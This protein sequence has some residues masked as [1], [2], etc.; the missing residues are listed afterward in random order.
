MTALLSVSKN[1]T[2]KVALYSAD[3]RRMGI[4]VEPPDV[5][6]SDW[7]FT[8]EDRKG[9]T[10]VIRFGLGAVKNVG[11]GPV[12]AILCAR[13]EGEFEDL[14]EFA[15]QVDL[16]KVGRRALESLIKVGALDKFGSRPT[17]L[18]AIERI[19]AI[20]STHFRAAESGQLS[21]FG[22]HTGVEDRIELPEVSFEISQREI[23][24]WERELIGLYVSD[25]P[26]NPVMEALQD[27]VTH[28]SG[29]LAEVS[30]EERVRVAGI[31]TRLRH[32]QTRTG[33]PMAFA[34]IEDIQGAIDLVI[35]PR[36][37]QRYS[38]MMEMDRILLV[39]GRVDNEGAEPKVLV[40]YI[41]TEFSKVVSVDA[42]IEHFSA[43]GHAQ[44]T[45]PLPEPASQEIGQEG[46]FVD[47]LDQVDAPP[48]RDHT[49]RFR[50]DVPGSPH[51]HQAAEPPISDPNASQLQTDESNEPLR[52]EGDWGWDDIPPPPDFPEDWDL[53]VEE[54]AGEDVPSER[55]EMP[56]AIA[57]KPDEDDVAPSGRQ[58]K[59]GPA[60]EPVRQSDESS[61]DS[62]RPI[63]IASGSLDEPLRLPHYLL[64]P[65]TVSESQKGEVRMVTVVLRSTGDK[66]RDVLRL[67]RIHGMITSYPGE[68][69]FAFH[70]FERGR[71]YL[72]EFPNFTAGVCDELLDRLRALVGNDNVRVERI[73]F[74]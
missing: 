53:W 38:E 32:H 70:V 23:L 27:V 51:Q 58:L 11:Q 10:S 40:D 14:N 59:S 60:V 19:M 21:L 33:K 7:D 43:A 55:E 22:L 66:M 42:Q 18:E 72:L 49:Q 30:P 26:L 25:H 64:S 57:R 5:N 63:P 39:D 1:E 48:P 68:D 9:G 65:S 16:R 67:R 45:P 37:W 52:E 12:E 69:R 6:V 4:P 2:E 29:Q 71:G 47:Q 73:T 31:V 3:C 15:L 35:F 34:T 8:I 28:Y 74:Q 62:G 61:D 13:E 17:L 36:T 56:V 50:T 24:N 41:T 46:Q 54:A 44:L 20:S